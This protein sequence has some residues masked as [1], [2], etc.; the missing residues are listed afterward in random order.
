[1]PR[2]FTDKK[3]LV[4]SSNKGKIIEIQ[5]LLNK[6]NVEPIAPNNFNISVPEETGATFIDNA[7]IKARHYCLKSGL[8]A[9][10]DD[11]G[12]CVDV[13]GGL[14]GIY[15]ARW[16]DDGNDFASAMARIQ[17]ET[18]GK[19][20]LNAHFVCALSLCWPDGHVENFEGFAYGRL[21]FPLRGDN[22]FGY[23]PI[24]IPEDYDITFAEMKLE[25]KHKISH[26]AAAFA[27]LVQGCFA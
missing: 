14:P 16:A 20:N 26:R 2:K 18:L 3:L 15:S 12:L 25:E 8:P 23:D 17:Q 9:L 1:M 5:D 19:S 21:T 24:F 7:V 27:K 13:L 11:S 6:Y 4:A 10:A 22:G